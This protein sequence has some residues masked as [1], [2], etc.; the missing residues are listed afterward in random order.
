MLTRLTLAVAIALVLGTKVAIAAIIGI[1]GDAQLVAPPASVVPPAAA[2]DGVI[3]VFDE[4]ASVALTSD[5]T[6]DMTVHYTTYNPPGVA[7]WTPATTGR[8]LG[9]IPMGTVVNSYYLHFDPLTFGGV[10]GSVTFDEPILAVIAEGDETTETAINDPPGDTLG[11]TN[12]LGDLTVPT[13][14]PDN[15]EDLGIEDGPDRLKLFEATIEVAFGA[16]SPG[17]RVRVLTVP[18]GTVLC[19]NG[20]LDPGEGCDDGNLTNGD[21]CFGCQTETC[22]A[23]SG[24]PSTCSPIVTCTNADGC[25]A[26]G[27]SAA[28]DSDCRPQCTAK[29]IKSVMTKKKCLLQLFGKVAS[30]GVPADPIKL[31]RCGARFA[32]DYFKEEL[33]GGCQTTGDAPA[34]EAKVDAFVADVVA[35]LDAAPAEDASKCR[36]QK[37]KCIDKYDQCILKLYAKAAKSGVIDAFQRTKCETKLSECFAKAELNVDCET[38]GDLAALQAKDDAFIVDATCELQVCF[39]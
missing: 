32:Y 33:K 3:H 17:D 14:Y 23:C 22:N 28:T 38:T 4:Q 39:P 26:P 7:P 15:G 21:G 10:L 13:L 35:E 2:E 11:P 27:C 19:G 5:L 25:C 29:K 6:A 24:E 34:L 8:T 30:K 16:S 37:L 31:Q 9:T 18:G 1:T 36:G 12:Y 20:V